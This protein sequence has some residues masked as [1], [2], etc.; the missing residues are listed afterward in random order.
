M[1][2]T[3]GTGEAAAASKKLIT[4]QFAEMSI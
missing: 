1:S 4:S 3:N 2:Q